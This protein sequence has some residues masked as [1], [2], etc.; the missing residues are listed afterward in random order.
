MNI[1]PKKNWHVRKKENIARVRRDEAQAAELEK[2]RLR[3]IQV[4]EKEARVQLLKE[5]SRLLYPNQSIKTGVKRK[6]KDIDEEQQTS[7]SHINFFKELEDGLVS[8]TGTNKDYEKEKK[9]EGEKYEKQ[10]G[11]LTYLGQDTVELTGNISWFNKVPERLKNVDSKSDYIEVA[12]DK[13]GLIDPIKDIKRYLGT[14]SS[15]SSVSKREKEDKE[16]DKEIERKRK[17]EDDDSSSHGSKHVKK[18]RRH[19]HEKDRYYPKKKKKKRKKHKKKKH[20]SC[21]LSSCSSEGGEGEDDD[22]VAIKKAKLEALRAQRLHREA[23]ESLRAKRVLAKLTG[24]ILPEDKKPTQDSAVK[25]K[26]HSQFNPHLAKQNFFEDINT[27][28]TKSTQ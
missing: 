25:Q 23:E 21:E 1:L 10:I 20:K 8:F 2:E 26:Y 5:K 27:K 14:N 9:E 18:K 19:S 3:K 4:A 16:K 24:E 28:N 17:R 12:S 6:E 15:S 13:K 22:R 11:Y 7:Q